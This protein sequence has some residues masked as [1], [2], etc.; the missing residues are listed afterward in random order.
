MVGRHME[1]NTLFPNMAIRM[2]SDIK[3]LAKRAK[4]SV[5]LLVQ[6]VMARLVHDARMALSEGELAGG[7]RNS[8]TWLKSV[9]DESKTV[10]QRL[11]TV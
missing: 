5:D 6:Q 9:V 11:A 3:A 1:G 10:M 7:A 4:G 8:V 2:S